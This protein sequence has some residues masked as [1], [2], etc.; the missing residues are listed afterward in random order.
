MKN[1]VG[2]FEIYVDDIDRAKAFYQDILDVTLEKLSDPTDS[3]VE[4]WC[5]PSNTEQY[6]ATGAL[7]KMAGFPAGQNS[8]VIYFSCQDCAIEE[9]RVS[10]AG[11]KVNQ[12]KMSI[13]QYGFCTLAYDSEGNMFGLHS[14]K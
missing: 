8:T 13:G 4:M 12:P 7:V 14:E 1:P 2:W 6:G 11:G 10:A 9:A 3:N 5:F